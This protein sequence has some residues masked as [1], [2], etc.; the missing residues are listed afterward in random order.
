MKNPVLKDIQENRID[1]RVKLLANKK[2]KIT[3]K[4]I[5][6]VNRFEDFGIENSTYQ[7]L[8]NKISEDEVGMKEIQLH[9]AT[10]KTLYYIGQQ[11][12]PFA[13]IEYKTMHE[14][15][16]DYGFVICPLSWYKKAI[17]EEN[18]KELY[19]F[20]DKFMNITVE[21]NKY[22]N[23]SLDN[24]IKFLSCKYFSFMKPGFEVPKGNYFKELNNF[25]SRMSL[26]DFTKCFNILA[27]Q[28]HFK[29]PKEALKVGNE[30]KIPDVERGKFKTNN[31]GLV[32]PIFDN[33]PVIFLNFNFM[34]KVYCIIVTSWD[35]I[36]DDSRIRS[37]I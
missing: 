19:T 4:V 21:N 13:V 34:R 2:S 1:K 32:K 15:A 25:W 36:A 7:Y 26:V 3:Q 31:I 30:I 37:I 28:D 8:K 18:I 14:I 10:S 6:E 5:K 24:I 12:F 23:E 22:D 27:P 35:K 11:F 16:T 33:D 17:P 20:K 9:N 29:I